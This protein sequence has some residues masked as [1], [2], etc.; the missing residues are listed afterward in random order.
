MNN[1][2]TIDNS[3][4]GSYLYTDYGNYIYG[5]FVDDKL[6]YIGQTTNIH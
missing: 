5:I 3:F 6:A 1:N 4:M 2:L